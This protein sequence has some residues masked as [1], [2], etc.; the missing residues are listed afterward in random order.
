VAILQNQGSASASEILAGALSEH[1]VA[2]L[3]GDRSFGKGSVQELINVTNDTA[4]K[5]TVARWYT[6]NGK[7]I[8][9]SGLTPDFQ[10]STTAE[11]LAA[12]KDPQ[13]DRA[14]KYLNTGN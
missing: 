11:D 2:K 3:V 14:I 8:S 9:L 5:V 7:S 12:G 6:P 4:I 13:M 10:A 1:G